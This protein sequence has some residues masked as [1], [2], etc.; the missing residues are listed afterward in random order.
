MPSRRQLKRVKGIKKVR[1]G[2]TELLKL[3]GVKIRKRLKDRGDRLIRKKTTPVKKTTRA[4]TTVSTTV[5]GGGNVSGSSLA[6][7]KQRV[8]NPYR[9]LPRI[10]SRNPLD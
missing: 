10:T 4:V 9:S 3:K 8:A 7:T 2:N 1:R 5:R 6:A